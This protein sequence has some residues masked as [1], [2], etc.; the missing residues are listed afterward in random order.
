MENLENLRDAEESNNVEKKVSYR[1]S[2]IDERIVRAVEEMGFETMTPIQEQ[3]IPI[4]LEGKD[5]IGQA[6]TGT[7][8][9]AAFGIPII[10]KIDPEEK[11]LQAIILCPTREL[12]MQAAEE[13]R[14]FAK[15]MCRFMVGRIF[16]GK[17]VPLPKGR[18]LWSVR[19]EG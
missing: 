16:R 4:M 10:Q 19:R 18:R 9:T 8:K 3:A 11:G 12:A 17:S 14:R 15:Y 13:I 5:L 6:Q 2:A 7:G 1:G